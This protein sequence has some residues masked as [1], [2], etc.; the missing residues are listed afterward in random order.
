[1]DKLGERHAFERAGTLPYDAL[2]AKCAADGADGI[3]AKDLK[4]I[5]D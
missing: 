2:M 5:R 4:H 1:M 3:P